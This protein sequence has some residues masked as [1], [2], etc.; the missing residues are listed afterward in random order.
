MSR[1][2][3]QRISNEAPTLGKEHILVKPRCDFINITWKNNRYEIIVYLSRGIHWMTDELRDG[4]ISNECL[5]LCYVA[6][7]VLA[8]ELHTK[9]K[10]E[11]KRKLDI[12]YSIVL[13]TFYQ[14]SVQMHK[15]I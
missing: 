8:R 10:L 2:A 15:G 3:N 6:N 5:L 7:Q 13:Y 9:M 4:Q 11:T 14:K 1:V 12:C